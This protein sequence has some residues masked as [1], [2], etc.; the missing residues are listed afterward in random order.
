MIDRI[1][2]IASDTSRSLDDRIE[3]L[4]TLRE[5]TEGWGYNQ[6]IATF[7][8]L[9]SAIK[10]EDG[11]PEHSLDLLMLY[12]LLAETYAENDVYRPLERL[13]VEVRG[14]LSREQFPWHSLKDAL[15]RII[16]ALSE[17]VY[18]HETYMLLISFISCAYEEGR[19]D[20]RL[21]KTVSHLLKLQI[22]LEDPDWH[23]HL[24]SNE[25]QAAIAR[26]FTSDELLQIMLHPAIGHL[27]ED[28]VEYTRRWEEIYYDVEDRLKLRFA[29]ERRRMG[30][31]FMYWSAKQDLLKEEYGIDW[32]TPSQMNP[33]V[34]FD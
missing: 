4:F 29:D 12:T 18:H 13:S 7:R 14:L 21:K 3:A 11:L 2:S 6:D 32:H 25:L 19:L 34:M 5:E 24:I 27:M 8:A 1:N 28:P 20:R 30:F 33:R 10:E 22:L 31:C 26:L 16:D 9:I 15:P 17:T 23:G